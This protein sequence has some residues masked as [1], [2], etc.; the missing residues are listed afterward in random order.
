MSSSLIDN[1]QLIFFKEDIL[2]DIRQFESR[3]TLKYNAELNKNSNKIL[4]MQEN[5]K[6]MNKKIEEFTSLVKTDLEMEQRTNNLSSLYTTLEQEVMTQGTKLKNTSNLLNDTI[7]KFNEELYLSIIYPGVIGPTGKFKTFHEFIDFVILN[8]NNLL[9]FKGKLNN[10]FKEFKSKTDITINNFQSKLDYTKKNCNAF[11]SISIRDNEKK[12]DE[13]FN[14]LLK[15]EIDIIKKKFDFLTEPQEE[16]V[17]DLINNSD[18]I[19]K[20]EEMILR[21]EDNENKKEIPIK[22]EIKIEKPN[23]NPKKIISSIVKQYIEGKIKDDDLFKRRRSSEGNFLGNKNNI[24]NKM[25]L[26]PKDRLNHNT[27]LFKANKYSKIL[28]K[29]NSF[30]SEPKSEGDND[31]EHSSFEQHSSKKENEYQNNIIKAKIDDDI[32]SNNQEVLKSDKTIIQKDTEKDNNALNYLHKLYQDSDISN[33]KEEKASIQIKSSSTLNIFENNPIN[34]KIKITNNEKKESE[35]IYSQERSRSRHFSVQKFEDLKP[36]IKKDI[37]KLSPIKNNEKIEIKN[38]INKTR[39]NNRENIIPN[40]IINKNELANNRNTKNYDQKILTKEQISIRSVANKPYSRNKRT[41]S[42]S[43]KNS[44]SKK[45]QKK[46]DNQNFSYNKQFQIN[47]S[48][49]KKIDMNSTAFQDN[50]T[51]EKDEQKMKKIFNQLENVIQEDEK[52]AIKNRFIKYGYNK[53]I[54]FAKNKKKI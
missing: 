23:N 14:G 22:K 54:I 45:S 36:N 30:K 3:L 32:Q 18:R 47:K 16:R 6:E 34:E 33:T 52:I 1:N 41:Y 27:K 5:L 46:M 44:N 11:T 9:T 12:M 40:K 49:V 26:S 13:K 31:S 43:P 48:E 7:N 2:K 39:Q 28:K 21:L 53:D 51:K 24:K 25:D 20:L 35:T 42:S 50:N 10:E 37:N 15:T 29:D 19:K 38:I 8:I 17:V 4:K